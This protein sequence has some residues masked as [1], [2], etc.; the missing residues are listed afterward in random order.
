MKKEFGDLKTELMNGKIKK[1]V[2]G[3]GKTC[4]MFLEL[5]TGIWTI[6]GIQCIA[7][8]GSMVAT[9]YW[10]AFF[11]HFVHARV[12]DIVYYLV[13]LIF[14]LPMWLGGYYYLRFF[15]KKEKAKLARA[16]VCNIITILLTCIWA[17]GGGY[18]FYDFPMPYG[19]GGAAAAGAAAAGAAGGAGAGAGGA[20][21]GGASS[22]GALERRIILYNCGG[23]FV[24]CLVQYHWFNCAKL[25]A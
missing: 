1:D 12:G 8:L 17:I 15:M 2:K 13:N 11:S 20:G 16:H 14:T 19:P 6:G 4:C 24:L 10:F 22:R 23:A 21:M 9:I 25:F 18:A 3:S 5:E 7:V